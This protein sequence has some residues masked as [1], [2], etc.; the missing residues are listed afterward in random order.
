MYD[1]YPK[2]DPEIFNNTL[3]RPEIFSESLGI[4]GYRVFEK[5]HFSRQNSQMRIFFAKIYKHG[6]FVAEF[7]KQALSESFARYSAV[8]KRLPT[9]A[10]L[11]HYNV[12]LST[13]D[14]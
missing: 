14:M 6:I 9:S 7:C 10:T 5:W 1:R 12:N 11:D 3:T 8:P 2:P 13:K 4:F